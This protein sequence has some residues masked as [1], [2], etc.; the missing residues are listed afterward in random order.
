M[1]PTQLIPATDPISVP[2]MWFEG[3]DLVT[4]VA[5]LLFMNV[6]FGGSIIALL[7][8]RAQKRGGVSPVP[9]ELS[10]RL[11]TLLALTVNL[12]VA[13]LL[14]IQVLYG[15]FLYTSTILMAVFW[16]SVILLVILAYYLLYIYDFKYR[17]LEGRR[18]L[19][20]GLSMALL[21]CVSFIF[22][23]AMTMMI[24]PATW[25]AYF[26]NAQGTL[27]NLSDPTLIPRYL[28]FVLAALA[29]GGLFIAFLGYG[30]IRNGN[31]G[32]ALL[33]S[34]LRWFTHATLAQFVIGTW[35][36]LSLKRDVLLA[37]MGNNVMET[38]VFLGSLAVSLVALYA[39]FTRRVVLAVGAT[40]ATVFLMAVMRA[41]LRL[42][43]LAPYFHPSNLELHPQYGPLWLFGIV[44]GVGLVLVVYMLKLYLRANK[45]A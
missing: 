43:Y 35:F 38:A 22:S 3:L 45:G 5:H 36:L 1:D 13:P 41:M 32:E 12:G 14:F 18:G 44:L 4:F 16:L 31:D 24:V 37:F 30:K 33:T 42:E 19:I 29:V 40:V 39:G 21:F 23:N 10:A 11:P 34:G 7:S 15:H 27:L 20:L 17:A 26:G 6:M 25:T 8:L 28:H 9:E 2:W